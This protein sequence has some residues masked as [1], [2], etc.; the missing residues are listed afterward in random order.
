M[1][2]TD[3]E[4]HAREL[5]A[6]AEALFK[7]PAEFVLGVTDV[8]ALPEGNRPEVAFAG[9]SNV[10]KSSLL[11]ALLSRRNLA[12]VS[13]TPGRTREVNYFSVGDALYVVDMP[14]Y[15]YAKAPKAL[16]KG[17][18]QLIHDYLRGRPQLKRVM[19]LI[20]SRHGLKPSDKEI[21]TLLDKAAVSYQGVL[22]KADK[23]KAGDLGQV[24][25]ETEAVMRTHPA[26]HPVVLTT[27]SVDGAGIEELR[28]A[29][30]ELC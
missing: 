21:M 22:T 4:N 1:T 27:S 20:D 11:N 10:G 6:R 24:V 25:R 18:T 30:A 7:A 29:I 8:A 9:R 2:P 3:E 16:V 14:G 23:P 28:A 13:N 5:A 15:G 19:L 17:W 12:R 26:A